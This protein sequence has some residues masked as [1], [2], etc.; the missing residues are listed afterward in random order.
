MRPCPHRAIPAR[1]S[2]SRYSEEGHPDRWSISGREGQEGSQPQRLPARCSRRLA[3]FHT[4]W[5]R[6]P[7]KPTDSGGLDIR[8]IVALGGK[9]HV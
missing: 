1:I 8:R 6:D 9:D 4:C 3:I 7:L 2:P 5:L